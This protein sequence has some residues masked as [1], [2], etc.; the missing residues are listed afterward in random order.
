MQKWVENIVSYLDYL[1]HQCHLQTSVHFNNERLISLPTEVILQLQQYNAHVNPYCILVKSGKNQHARCLEEQRQILNSERSEP[2]CH[3][4]F[5]GVYEYIFPFYEEGKI[6]GYI[7]V[8]GFRHHPVPNIIQWD[9]WS[10]EL[11]EDELPLSLCNT[12]IPPLCLMFEKLFSLCHNTKENEYNNLLQYLNEVHIQISLDEICEHFHCSR[13]HISH[14]FK[15]NSGMT[16]SAYCNQLK[17]QDGLRLLQSTDYSVSRIAYEVGFSD[18]GYFI[19]LFRKQYH[20]SPLQY[21]KNGSF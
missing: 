1:N 16:I 13:S 9:S 2:F 3:T 17:L 7:A 21:R 10:R 20:L 18:P 14:L 6:I 8:S 12:L 4:C 15:K 5:A 19:R 11:R